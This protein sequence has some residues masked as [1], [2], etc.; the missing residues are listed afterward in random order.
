MSKKNRGDRNVDGGL[1]DA[2]DELGILL[3]QAD[4][5]MYL[6]YGGHLGQRKILKILSGVESMGQKELQQELNVKA[7]SMSE[8]ITK[9]EKKG[10][11]K[12][13]RDENDKRRVVLEITDS[14]REKARFMDESDKDENEKKIGFD[15]LSPEE[16]QML[17]ILLTKLLDGWKTYRIENDIE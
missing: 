9:L 6:M 15:V 14:G 2:Q 16:Q 8:I 1:V 17:H 4:H 3:N 11:I 13:V 7:G 5:W 12:R 10:D